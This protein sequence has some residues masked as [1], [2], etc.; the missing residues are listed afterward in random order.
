MLVLSYV[1][2]I[3]GACLR[4]I[5]VDADPVIYQ[6]LIVWHLVMAAAVAGFAAA[7]FYLSRLANLRNSGV[8]GVATVLLLLVGLQLGLGVSTYVVKFGWPAWFANWSLAARFIIPEKT[9][10]QVNLITA[11]VAVGSLILVASTVQA[12]RFARAQGSDPGEPSA[13]ALAGPGRLAAD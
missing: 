12:L 2:L 5:P 7:A 10:L 13:E 8:R 9:F 1:Q 4:H 11:H 3:L 6:F